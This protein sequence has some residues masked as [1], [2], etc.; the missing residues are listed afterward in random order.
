MARRQFTLFSLSFLD[1]MSCGFGAVI[2]FFMI[3]NAQM[4]ARSNELT[5]TLRAEAERLETEMLSGSKQLVALRNSLQETQH[6]Q[7]TTEGLSRSVV[8]SLTRRESEVAELDRDT[9]ARARRINEL[10][11]DLKSLE[12][13]TLRLKAGSEARETQG[14]RL[15][16]FAGEGDR[17]Y[18]TGLR[19]GGSHILI[20]V[21]ASASMLADNIVNILRR[22]HLPDAEKV[23][24]AKWRQAVGTVDWL[25]TQLPRDS[26]F[27]IQSFNVMTSPVVE[28]DAKGWLLAGSGR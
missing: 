20:L 14:E 28:G 10:K 1:I 19:L 26:R 24:S 27:Q 9:L 7:R 3:I 15:R 18:L 23:R 8:E 17:Q 21:D 16:A 12:Q 2:L 22:R 13:G 25:T 6:E 4:Q 5:R 11:T